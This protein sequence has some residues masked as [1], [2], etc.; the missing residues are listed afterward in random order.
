MG[1]PGL[2]YCQ[3]FSEVG[4]G[5]MVIHDRDDLPRFSSDAPVVSTVR[6]IC[7]TIVDVQFENRS[8]CFT[9]TA[10]YGKRSALADVAEGLGAIVKSSVSKKLDYLVIGALSTPSWIY[11]TYG[12]KIE[13]VKDN[14]K[15]GATTVI[16]HEDDFLESARRA[17]GLPEPP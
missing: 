16:V 17:A 5:N 7:D 12:R 1:N 6:G 3:S 2:E 8:F 4:T 13:E 15:S 9:G 10:S 11:S 14:R